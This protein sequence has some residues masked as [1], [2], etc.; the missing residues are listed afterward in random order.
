M[1]RFGLSGRG[2][3]FLFILALI[4]LVAGAAGAF[5]WAKRG[6]EQ[7]AA[8]QARHAERMLAMAA[9]MLD[10]TDKAMELL[11]AYAD[12]WQ[13]AGAGER[14]FTV[15]LTGVRRTLDGA[16][17]AVANARDRAAAELAELGKPPKRYAEAHAALTD[18]FGHYAALVELVHQPGGT[19]DAFTAR[20]DE[21]RRLIGERAEDVKRL[22]E[23]GN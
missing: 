5:R 1:H 23:H 4:V 17:N 8:G 22:L 9:D 3:A 16:V 2:K 15:A 14:D 13:R 18:L 20:V 21:L 19:L 11:D 6:A 7:A 10:G 12:A